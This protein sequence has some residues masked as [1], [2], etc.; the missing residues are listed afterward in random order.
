M[1]HC[2][3]VD[4]AIPGDSQISQKVSV[5]RQ[6]YSDLKIEVQK[7]WCIRTSVAPVIIGYLGSIPKGLRKQLQTL[8]IYHASL[9]P[10]IQKSVLLNSCHILCRFVTEH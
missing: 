10:K 7:L 4:V 9:I 3:L 5:K 8:Q 2:F 6:C 1:K